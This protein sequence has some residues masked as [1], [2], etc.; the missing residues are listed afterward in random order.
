MCIE[1]R[2]EEPREPAKTLRVCVV[3]TG[4]QSKKEFIK[5]GNEHLTFPRILKLPQ[6]SQVHGAGCDSL[7][8]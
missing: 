3:L 1:K 7:L 4:G 8:V 5:V 2:A 6:D